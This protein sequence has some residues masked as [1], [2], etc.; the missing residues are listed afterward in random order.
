MIDDVYK[1]DT[2]HAG[3]TLTEQEQDA[4][5]N[6]IKDSQHVCLQFLPNHCLNADGD[7]QGFVF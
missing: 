5:L 1:I 7:L 2:Q 6:C 4:A 3:R